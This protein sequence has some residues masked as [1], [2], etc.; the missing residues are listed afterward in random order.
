VKV[1]DLVK[2]GERA[3]FQK[4]G[5]GSV[6]WLVLKTSPADPCIFVES[7]KTGYRMWGNKLAYEVINE[8]R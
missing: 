3:C 6:V 5:E 7:L 2:A 4:A 1:G 8:A